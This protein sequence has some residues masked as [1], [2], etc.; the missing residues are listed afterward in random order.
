MA[1]RPGV[2]RPETFRPIVRQLFPRRRRIYRFARKTPRPFQRG[3]VVDGAEQDAR[4][5]RRGQRQRSVFLRSAA[6]LLLVP[7]EAELVGW[8]GGEVERVETTV[9]RVLDGV[10][11]QRVHRS[12]GLMA[13]VQSSMEVASYAPVVCHDQEADGIWRIGVGGQ[14][15]MKT[16]MPRGQVRD[17]DEIASGVAAYRAVQTY[18]LLVQIGHH[19]TRSGSRSRG[20]GDASAPSVPDVP[21]QR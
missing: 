14:V 11:E 9:S 6:P 3:K 17:L 18:R 19:A 20:G 21:A 1:A 15:Q 10:R 4:S 12:C 5:P 7:D 2:T 16:V 13:T 8:G